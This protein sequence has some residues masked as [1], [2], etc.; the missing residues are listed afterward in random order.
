MVV[1]HVKLSA[2]ASSSSPEA[3]EEEMEFLHECAASASVADVAAALGALAGLQARLL[4][5]CHRLRG[6]AEACGA[7]AGAAGELE[8]ALDEAEAYASKEQVQHNKFLLPHALREHI[9]NIQKKCAT[10]LQ[11]SP[12]ALCLQQPSSGNKHEKI[13]L[14][15]AGKELAMGQKL[16]DYIGVNDKTKIVIR[17]TQAPD[18]P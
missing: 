6:S 18:E 8:R 10:A 15:W 17:L 13:Q 3:A 1:L 12:E 5:L 16:S 11:E 9:K 4:S 14:W 2:P 7:D